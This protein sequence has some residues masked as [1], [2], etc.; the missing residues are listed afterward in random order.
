M[1]AAEASHGARI[2]LFTYLAAL[3][4]LA[5]CGNVYYY[6]GAYYIQ[7]HNGGSWAVQ[8]QCPAGNPVSCSSIQEPD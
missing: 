2:L 7:G 1:A 3:I 4:G 8:A 5:R 6:T